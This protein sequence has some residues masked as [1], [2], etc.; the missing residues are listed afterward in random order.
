MK[1]NIITIIILLWAGSTFAQHALTYQSYAK[2]V[3]EQDT[4]TIQVIENAKCLKIKNIEKSSSNSIP[5]YAEIS[6][7]VDFVHDSVY[8]ILD[9]SDGKFYSSYP[10][11]DN[12]VVFS[13]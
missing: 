6:T 4:T 9:Y 7:Y 10:L 1:Q 13:E 11:T 8:T 2:G 3:A 5:G 12:D